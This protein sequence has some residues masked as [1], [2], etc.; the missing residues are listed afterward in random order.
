MFL[1]QVEVSVSIASGIQCN[2]IPLVAMIS[3]IKWCGRV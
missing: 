3:Q 1:V 2:G